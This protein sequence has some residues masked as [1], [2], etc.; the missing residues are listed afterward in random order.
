M[1]D[2]WPTRTIL[3]V[4]NTYKRG[5][6]GEYFLQFFTRCE[7]SG[8][9]LWRQTN[10]ANNIPHS[11]PV[12][13]VLIISIQSMFSTFG[14]TFPRLV[15]TPNYCEEDGMPR[16][17][18][19]MPSV[20]WVCNVMYQL[21][22]RSIRGRFIIET[23]ISNALHKF[24]QHSNNLPVPELVMSTLYLDRLQ[25]ILFFYHPTFIVHLSGENLHHAR[26]QI[27]ILLSF[28]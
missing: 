9:L 18:D 3:G 16:A 27:W 23:W 26:L 20:V 5:G 21:S 13:L 6:C 4:Q 15:P 19:M 14:L 2:N 7:C 28:M 10:S 22:S 12:P 1:S 8:I 25:W 11:I 17:I 24:D